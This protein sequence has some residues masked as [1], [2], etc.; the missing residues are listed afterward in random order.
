[1]FSS[2]FNTVDVS[3][4]V[5]ILAGECTALWASQQHANLPAVVQITAVYPAKLMRGGKRYSFACVHDTVYMYVKLERFT[6]EHSLR[7][8]VYS[9]TRNIETVGRLGWFPHQ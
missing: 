8:V 5:V 4:M 3:T 6:V 7:K 1:M 2:R 9:T